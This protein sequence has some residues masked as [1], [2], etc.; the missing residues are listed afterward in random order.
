MEAEYL[1]RVSLPISILEIALFITAF[2]L[3]FGTG[4]LWHL[5]LGSFLL[6]FVVC[7]LASLFWLPPKFEFFL[8]GNTV[9]FTTVPLRRRS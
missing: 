1:P 8:R 6:F 9:S 3:L 5:W 7:S 2:V 4:E